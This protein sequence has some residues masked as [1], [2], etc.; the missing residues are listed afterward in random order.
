MGKQSAPKVELYRI[1]KTWADAKSQIGAY[2]VLENAIKACKDGYYV[3]DSKGNVVFPEKELEVAPPVT[4]TPTKK[5]NVEIAKEVIAGKWGNGQERKDRLAAAGYDYNAVQAEVSKLLGKTEPAKPVLKSNAEIAK[6]V[7]EG[8]W[9]NGDA[10]KQALTKAGYDYAAVQAE[11]QK[12]LQP[13]TPKPVLKSNAEIAKEV[14]AGKWGN[15]DARKKALEAAGY[16]YAAVQAEVQKLVNGNNAAKGYKIMVNTGALNVRKGAGTNYGVA[17]V[18][19]KGETYTIV[20]EKS[21]WGK[22]SDGSGWV[23]LNYTKRV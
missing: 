3:F 21:G 9:G 2:G 14:M 11:V 23:S 22:L 16:N 7:I 20:E 18:I 4:P 5:S 15:G 8:K 6:E 10:R 1:R 13:A 17:K 19:R 12:L